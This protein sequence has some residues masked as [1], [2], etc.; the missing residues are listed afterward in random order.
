MN[1]YLA[2]YYDLIL[3]NPQ[4]PTERKLGTTLKRTRR[5]LRL[6]DEC[7][8]DIPL[9]ESL[10]QLLSNDILLDEVIRGHND[11]YTHLVPLTSDIVG[12]AWSCKK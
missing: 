9:K 3:L 11:Y 2:K 5:R 12:Y 6:V 4:E 10:T 7:A 8:Y 1:Y